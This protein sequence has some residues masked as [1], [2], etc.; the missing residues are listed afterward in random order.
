MDVFLLEVTTQS[1][2]AY[3]AF[4]WQSRGIFRHEKDAELVGEAYVR[5]NPDEEYTVTTLTVIEELNFS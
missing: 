5:S 2:N 1:S 4:E 3:N